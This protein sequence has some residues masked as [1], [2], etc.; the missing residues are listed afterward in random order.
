[1]FNIFVHSRGSITQVNTDKIFS[2]ISIIEPITKLDITDELDLMNKSFPVM[3]SV[4]ANCFSSLCLRFY[5]VDQVAARKDG[6]IMLSIRDTQAKL[7]ANFVQI[8]FDADIEELYI[9]CAA[10]ISRS[11]GVAAAISKFYTGDD[12]FFYKNY[13]PNR[14]VYIKVL[15]ALHELYKSGY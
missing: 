13:V 8:C 12:E 3:A 9:N 4:K 14:Y 11:A 5:D 6:S 10:G 7:I 1:M 15:E 2:L